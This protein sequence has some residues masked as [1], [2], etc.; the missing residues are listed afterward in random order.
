MRVSNTNAFADAVKNAIEFYAKSLGV[1]VIEVVE[2]C[3]N[4]ES[5][6]QCIHLLTLAQSDSK[7][8]QTI[9]ATL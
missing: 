3:K 8:L 2:L 5:T 4:H 6:K 7:K 1:S 9:S